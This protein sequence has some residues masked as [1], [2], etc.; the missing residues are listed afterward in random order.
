MLLFNNPIARL[1]VVI[2]EIASPSI[3]LMTTKEMEMEMEM[4]R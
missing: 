3:S 1:N 2:I 4:E